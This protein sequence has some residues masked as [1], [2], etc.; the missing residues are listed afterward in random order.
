MMRQQDNNPVWSTPIRGL[1]PKEL[2]RNVSPSVRVALLVGANDDVAPPAMSRDCAETLK[3]RIN[4]VT[5]TIAPGLGHEILLEPVTYE[6]LKGLV[7]SLR[8]NGKR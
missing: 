5:L 6:A 3:K 8:S 1:S 7:E 2:A 4:H